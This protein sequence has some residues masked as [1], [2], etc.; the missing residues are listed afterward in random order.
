MWFSLCKRVVDMRVCAAAMWWWQAA[1]WHMA[2]AQQCAQPTRC[3]RRG[4]L[5]GMFVRLV[6]GGGNPLAHGISTAVRTAIQVRAQRVVESMLF[7]VQ[8]GVCKRESAGW[9]MFVG[10]VCV[11]S[12]WW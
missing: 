4:C 9:G 5:C 2:S 3:G 11:A 6:C 10:N 12:V 1:H 8:E 7:S